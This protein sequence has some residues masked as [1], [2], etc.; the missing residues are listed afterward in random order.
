MLK[1]NYRHGPPSG[2][3]FVKPVDIAKHKIDI[4]TLFIFLLVIS[5]IVFL[6]F[7]SFSFL[8]FHEN[9][10]FGA[11]LFT[12]YPFCKNTTVHKLIFNDNSVA[13]FY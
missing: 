13:K 1:P 7:H 9:K 3:H 5:V 2:E 11:S 12:S 6:K 4:E 8:D 10:E